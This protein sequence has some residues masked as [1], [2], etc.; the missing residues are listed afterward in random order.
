M[1]RK[2]FIKLLMSKGKQRN[3]ARKTAQFYNNLNVSYSRAYECAKS[4]IAM[5]NLSKAVQK[6]AISMQLMEVGINNF[7]DVANSCLKYER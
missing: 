7:V 2:R 1:T 3:E 5:S 6:T 4:A